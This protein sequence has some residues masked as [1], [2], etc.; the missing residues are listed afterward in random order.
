LLVAGF[1]LKTACNQ[2]LTTCNLQLT[3]GVF[4]G[5]D[6]RIPL[7]LVFLLIFGICT[8][9]DA[10]L[11]QKSLGMDINLDWG[12]IMFAFGAIMFFFGKRHKS[13]D[14]TLT[15]ADPDPAATHRP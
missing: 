3:T 13:P 12:G 10:A 4:M 9:G 5:L 14:A 1:Q 11:Y 2:Q 6:I 15:H 8:H 7:G